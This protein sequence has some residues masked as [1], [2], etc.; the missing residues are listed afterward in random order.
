MNTLGH[1]VRTGGNAV[2][3][4]RTATYIVANACFE[5]AEQS[6]FKDSWVIPVQDQR[7]A[8]LLIFCVRLIKG[9]GNAFET[10]DQE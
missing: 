9:D 7:L 1:T 10:K 4:R 2:C 5:R 8:R 6:H 3:T